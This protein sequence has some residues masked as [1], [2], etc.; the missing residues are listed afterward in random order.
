[1]RGKRT[2]V[3]LAICGSLLGTAGA[4]V[5]APG[6][7]TERAAGPGTRYCDLYDFIG[8]ACGY[9][10]GKRYTDYGDRGEHVKEI[11]ALLTYFGYSVGRYGI[12]GHFGK[13]TRSAV[14]RF[15]RNNG[16]ADDGIVG[17]NTWWHLRTP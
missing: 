17:P 9:Y 5:A 12:D 8:F 13:D 16:I 3:T 15:Q 4:A 1:M 14:M 11:Q 10:D 7:T 6:A 2:L